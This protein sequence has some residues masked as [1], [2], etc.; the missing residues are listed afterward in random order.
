MEIGKDVIDGKNDFIKNDPCAEVKGSTKECQAVGKVRVKLEDNDHHVVIPAVKVKENNCKGIGAHLVQPKDGTAP[1]LISGSTNDNQI[2]SVPAVKME[3]ASVSESMKQVKVKA[4]A[5]G[6]SVSNKA[7][8]YR[9]TRSRSKAKGGRTMAL[10]GAYASIREAPRV[11]RKPSA[12]LPVPNPIL[13]SPASNELT[14]NYEH[15]PKSNIKVQQYQQVKVEE[16]SIVQAIDNSSQDNF[17]RNTKPVL[18]LCKTS[19]VAVS[20]QIRNETP[21]APTRAQ[22]NSVSF[23]GLPSTIVN[24]ANSLPTR[25]RGFSIDLDRKY[26]Q[27]LLLHLCRW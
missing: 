25:K 14:D 7:S 17:L 21:V 9:S 15:L 26:K 23:K 24:S 2:K 5:T 10:K 20:Q 16:G 19:S 6:S 3:N 8:T 27:K 1:P 13:P 18:P 22:N 4:Q 12:S 11:L